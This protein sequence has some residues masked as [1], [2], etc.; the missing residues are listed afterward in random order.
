MSNNFEEL[1]RELERLFGYPPGAFDPLSPF[2][3]DVG[4]INHALG[5]GFTL[6]Q[7]VL[8][9]QQLL[10]RIEAAL[11]FPAPREVL[12][13]PRRMGILPSPHLNEKWPGV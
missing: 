7:N 11:E 12:E 6:M 5:E 13:L 10:D 9:P 4:R 8:G 2:L 3:R 1:R